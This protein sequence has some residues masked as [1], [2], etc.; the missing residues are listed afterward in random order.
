[1]NEKINIS[2]FSKKLYE[3]IYSKSKLNIIYELSELENEKIDHIS[4]EKYQTWEWNYGYAPKY[5]YQKSK[6]FPEGKLEI[7]LQTENSIMHILEIKS[8]FLSLPKRETLIEILENKKHNYHNIEKLLEQHSDIFSEKE[9]Y[10]IMQTI[11]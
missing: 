2:Q 10:Q 11:I 6:N 5:N 9:R 4:K 3:F 1:L 8:N 7:S